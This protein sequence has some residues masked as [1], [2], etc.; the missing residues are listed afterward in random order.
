[1]ESVNLGHIKTAIATKV[2]F[3]S[4]AIKIRL[5]LCLPCVFTT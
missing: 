2:T 3:V 5:V 4:G 1:M